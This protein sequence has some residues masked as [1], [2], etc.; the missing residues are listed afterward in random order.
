MSQALLLQWIVLLSMLLIG[1]SDGHSQTVQVR[2]FCESIKTSELF[3]AVDARSISFQL[4]PGGFAPDSRTRLAN[5]VA[6][7]ALN[8][9]SGILYEPQGPIGEKRPVC[10]IYYSNPLLGGDDKIVL[11]E[12]KAFWNRRD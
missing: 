7:E 10:A 4:Q 11:A 3:G 12:F 5:T 9:V 2:K 1:C 8:K 6:P